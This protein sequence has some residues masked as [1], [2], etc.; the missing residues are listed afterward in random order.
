[1]LWD[2]QRN[3]LKNGWS[4]LKPGGILVYSTCSLSY[5]QNEDVI[6]WF[7][8]HF[9][10]SKLEPIPNINNLTVAPLKKSKYVEVDISNAV[11]FDPIYSNTS[12]FFVA[13]IRK[14]VLNDI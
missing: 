13:R 14:N 9:A 12:G 7:L 4:L 5:K 6:G 11:R 2:L 3:L 10:N 8:S 1:N